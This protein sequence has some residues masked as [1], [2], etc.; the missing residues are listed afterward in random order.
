MGRIG[1]SCPTKL[2]VHFAIFWDEYEIGEN[3]EDSWVVVCW[4]NIEGK[5]ALYGGKES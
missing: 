1:E 3:W 4:K 2:N 5:M